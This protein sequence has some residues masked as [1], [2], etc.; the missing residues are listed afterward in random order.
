MDLLIMVELLS[1]NQY[2]K[3]V[4]VSLNLILFLTIDKVLIIDKALTIDKA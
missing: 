1:L 4:V 3:I 2:K